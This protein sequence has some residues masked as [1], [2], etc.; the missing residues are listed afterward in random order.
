MREL[1]VEPKVRQSLQDLLRGIPFIKP[2]Q[3]LK[4]KSSGEVQPDLLFEVTLK[5]R[6]R[7]I[8]VEVKSAGEPRQVRYAVQQ[9][10]EYLTQFEDAYGMVGAPYISSDAAR[11]CKESGIGY[12]DLAGNCLLN[13][14]QIYIER[15]NF[16]N[17]NVERRPLRSLFAPKSSRVL[18][19][20]LS[21]SMRAWQIQELVKEAK[22]SLGSVFKVKQ[23]LLDLEYALEEDKKVSLK[24][25]MALL[26]KWAESYSFRKNRIYD[27]FGFAELNELERN[28]AEYCQK[29][30][31]PYALTLFSGAARV[32]PFAR[33]GRGF[34]YVAKRIR[35]VAKS[36][37]LKE[38]PSGPNF[39]ILEPYDE[40]VFY[41]NR[42]IGGLSVA[43]DIQLYLDLVGYKGRGKESANF[44]LKQRIEPRW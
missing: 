39:T 7:R 19:V 9:L 4:E 17:P 36:V 11:I 25:P 40:G 24:Q 8:V 1:E 15:K 26:D 21:N 41:G 29:E 5:N 28:I 13:F 10:K 44:L 3:F 14:E 18:R 42:K 23:R 31:I 20:M 27:Y 38:V 30:K 32:A 16:P 34:V 33:Y 37:G 6:R 12:I 2:G 35:E 43:C 22:V